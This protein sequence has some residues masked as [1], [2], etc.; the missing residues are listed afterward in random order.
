MDFDRKVIIVDDFYPDPDKIRNIALSAEYEK[1]GLKNY[2]G[3]NTKKPYWNDEV[4]S[5]FSKAIGEE[6]YPTPTSSCGH[7]RYT[8]ENDKSTQIIHFD[9][10][11]TQKWAG[12]VYLSL[13]EHYEGHDSGTKI[14]SHKKSGMMVAPK[15]HIE[16]QKIGVTTIDDMKRFFETDGVDEFLWN[17]ELNVPIKYNRLVLFRPWI[18]HGISSHFG[19]NISNCRLTHLI[20]LDVK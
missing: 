20:F 14:Y 3:N 15:D 18:W 7:F 11:P 2:P 5:L 6:V 9:P 1:D 8:R 19:D 4:N 17:I 12:V 13:P 10:K 16:A